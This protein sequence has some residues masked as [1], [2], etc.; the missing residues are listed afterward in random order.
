MTQKKR[1][2]NIYR[3]FSMIFLVFSFIIFF[4]A[5]ILKAQ[6]IDYSNLIKKVTKDYTKKYC[7]AIAFGLSKESAMNFS[8]EENR[9][10]FKNRKGIN[11][12]DKETLAEEIAISVIENCGYPLNMSGQKGIEE[13]KNY[14]LS[15]YDN[16]QK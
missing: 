16:A 3:N 9:Q 15:K 12:L 7:N 10:V 14:Y 6:N 1:L 2:T 5:N 13:F 11:Y 4:N 8:I